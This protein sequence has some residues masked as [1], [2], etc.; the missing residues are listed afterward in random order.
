[1]CPHCGY[2]TGEDVPDIHVLRPGTILNDRYLLG[3]PLGQGGFGITYI[4]RDRLLDIRVAV[5][6]YFPSGYALRNAETSNSVTITDERLRQDILKGRDSFLKEA[7]ILAR[8]QGTPGIVNVLNFFEANDTAYIVME[9][10]EGET[11]RQRIKRQK[12]TADEVFGRMSPI[13][14]TLEKVHREGIVHRD[15]SPDNIMMLPDGSLKLMDFG[16]ARLM[17][18]GDQRSVS[19]VLKAGYAPKEQYSSKGQQGPWTDIYALC[20]TIYKCITGITP[21]DALDRVDGDNLKWPSEL[22]FPISV[23]QEAV[24]KKGMAISHRNRFQT[25]GELKLALKAEISGG[26]ESNPL[27]QEPLVPGET[28]PSQDPIPETETP[29]QPADVLEQTK[30]DPSPASPKQGPSHRPVP[31]ISTPTPTDSAAQPSATKR[32]GSKKTIWFALGVAGLAMAAVILAILLKKEKTPTDQCGLTPVSTAVV[33]STSSS[34]LSPTEATI[35]SSSGEQEKKVTNLDLEGEYPVT[36]WCSSQI[37]DLTGNQIEAFNSSNDQGIKIIPTIAEADTSYA[38][39]NMISYGDAGADIFFFPQDQLSRFVQSGILNPLDEQS[40]T[41]VKD[42]NAAA[43]AS[44]ASVDDVAYA[45]PVTSDNTF[46]VFYDKRI[47]KKSSLNDLGKMIADC[48]TA[49]MPFCFEL[50]SGWYM[51]SFFFG[52]GCWSNWTTDSSG[53]FLSVNDTFNSDEG[54]QAAKAVNA[55]MRSKMFVNSSSAYMFDDGAGFVIS[56][57]WHTD[58]AKAILGDNFGVAP[59]PQFTVDG[60]QYQLRPFIGYSMIGIKT[61]ADEKL[62][63]VC[64]QLARYLTGETAQIERFSYVGWGPS[65]T[66]AATSSIVRADE[67]ISCIGRQAAFSI[68]QGQIPAAWWNSATEFGE[69]LQAAINDLEIKNALNA[70]EQNLRNCLD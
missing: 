33:P 66:A 22:G 53:R 28:H 6:E 57:S 45:Y 56:G 41:F 46:F 7:R 48:E 58:V 20:A 37:M 65:N 44:A 43:A 27:T 24:L 1:M 15:I 29:T 63:A 2:L 36:I 55:V 26:T 18:Y 42:N 38:I 21:E 62:N 32:K 35:A 64:H 17:N 4:G 67:V 23:Q 54:F 12:I 51:S 34:I 31:P 39:D 49:N 47:V 8:F 25:I 16:A 52:T 11:L 40:T 19:V 10:L 14:D 59:L 68:P 13:F 70:Y 50:T 69:N 3:L 61:H 60:K 30:P 9:F 5:K